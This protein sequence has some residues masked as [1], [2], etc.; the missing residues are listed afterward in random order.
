MSLLFKSVEHFASVLGFTSPIKAFKP[1]CAVITW[2]V[3]AWEAWIITTSVIYTNASDTHTHTH[4]NRHKAYLAV[5]IH[6]ARKQTFPMKLFIILAILFIFII[7]TSKVVLES[8]NEKVNYLLTYHKHT[9]IQV[10]ECRSF[11]PTGH[12]KHRTKNTAWHS[13]IRWMQQN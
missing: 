6:V 9:Q 5:H 4:T 1:S 3:I 11:P 7:Q 10:Y 2:K 8:K 12:Q 13:W